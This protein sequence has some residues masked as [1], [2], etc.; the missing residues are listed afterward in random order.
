MPRLPPVADLDA[1]WRCVVT[2]ALNWPPTAEQRS[3]LRDGIMRVLADQYPLPISTNEL[4]DL[5]GVPRGPWHQEMYRQL[6]R[7]VRLGDVEKV[8]VEGAYCRYWRLAISEANLPPAPTAPPSDAERAALFVCGTAPMT[9]PAGEPGTVTINGYVCPWCAGTGRWHD[10]DRCMNCSTAGVT[11]TTTPGVDFSRDYGRGVEPPEVAPVPLPRP[12]AVMR[13]PCLDCAYRPGSP[14]EDSTARPDGS[15]PFFCHHGM[16]RVDHPDG[17]TTYHAASYVGALP[18]GY[19]VCA[20]WWQ[21]FAEGKA[22][23]ETAFRDPGGS[24]RAS[25]PALPGGAGQ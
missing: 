3:D 15:T 8:V 1:D 17:G 2:N 5:L 6:T 22:A 21:Q 24:D 25:A 7:F 23:P 13:A 11:D 20:G 18:L 12:P 9:R 19:F 14:E 4:G 16:A 10:G